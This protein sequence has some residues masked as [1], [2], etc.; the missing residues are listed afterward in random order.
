MSVARVHRTAHHAEV[1]APAG[2]VYGVIADAALWPLC[3]PRH[4]H[5]EQLD[6]G[7]SRDRLQMWVVADGAVRSWTTRRSL[8]TARR[9]VDFRWEVPAAPLTSMGGG[10]RVDRIAADRTRLTLSHD[11]TLDT[12][13]ADEVARVERAVAETGAATLA[14]LAAFAEQWERLD[15]LLLSFE[16]SVRVA[17]PAEL[18]Y[19]YLYRLDDW[20]DAHPDVSRM[21][22]REDRP[23][24]QFLSVD[25]RGDDGTSF[26]RESVRIGFPHA[27]RIVHKQT[28]CTDGHPLSA[29]HV[30]EWSVEPDETGVTVVGQH[31]VFLDQDCVRRRFGEG[32][33]AAGAARQRVRERLG[34]YSTVTL[35]LARTRAESALGPSTG[36]RSAVP[37][38]R[39]HSAR[40][41]VRGVLRRLS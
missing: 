30:G 29:A 28:G 13:A 21:S 7:A 17:G 19:D 1:A 11:F 3:L 38:S 18:A 37:R 16:D 9:R 22:L 31:R 12:D 14:G 10:W 24:V 35:D 41:E 34:R 25:V 39:P 15:D 40:P 27:G 5:V 23:G 20:A 8:D 6:F 33:E 2:V 4:V 32:E 26:T 36:R